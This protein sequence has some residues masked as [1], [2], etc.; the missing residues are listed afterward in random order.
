MP[1]PI[2]KEVRKIQLTG[3]STYI[4]SLPKNWVK[5]SK[6]DKGSQVVVLINDDNSLLI[7]P[8][9]IKKKISNESAVIYV[10][11]KDD[12]EIIIRKLIAIYLNGYSSIHIRCLSNAFGSK[13]RT[14]IRSFVKRMLVGTEIISETEKEIVLRVLLS[15]PTL[16]AG[17]V[18]RRMAFIAESMHNAAIKSLEN[19]DKSLAKDVI[20][21]DDDVDRF[22]LYIIRQLRAASQNS[23][24]LKEIGLNDIVECF[25]YRLISKTIERVADHAAKI[26]ERIISMEHPLGYE[27]YSKIKE[28]SVL[29]ITDFKKA[30]DS[31]Y[32]RDFDTAND[33]INNINRV[34]SIENEIT[35]KLLEF[36]EVHDISNY[37]IIMES[38]RRTA[39]YAGDIAEI[40]LDLTISS[41]LKKRF[42]C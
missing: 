8:N 33:I 13:Q 10:S 15:Y 16:T 12:I 4:L 9:D 42:N 23:Q 6:L 26:S 17:S 37:R 40:V 1:E 2:K 3:G 14:S 30:I 32:K 24:I 19:L 36:K 22:N 41:V 27:I 31:L 25:E 5:S 18:L 35:N 29:A 39:E 7:L 28:M 34:I 21:M 11:K 20:S 38:I